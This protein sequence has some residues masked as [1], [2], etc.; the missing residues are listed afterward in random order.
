MRPMAHRASGV[1]RSLLKV[2]VLFTMGFAA[3]HSRGVAVRLTDIAVAIRVFSIF[4]ESEMCVDGGKGG[5]GLMK[6]WP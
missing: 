3:G 5:C 6:R 2:I 1:R 4:M